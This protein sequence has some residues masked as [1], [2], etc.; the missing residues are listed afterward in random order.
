MSYN[1]YY[2][3]KSYLIVI[4]LITTHFAFTQSEVMVIN[5]YIDYKKSVRSNS[6]KEM[7]SIGFNVAKAV[8]DLRYAG[9]DNFVGKKMYPNSIEGTFMRQPAVIALGR[10]QKELLQQD[11][12]IK[13]FDAYRP[14]SVSKAFWEIVKDERY[15]ANPIR[16]SNH[17]RGTAIDLTIIDIKTG[18]ELNMG[19]GFD[20]FT[21]TAHHSFTHLSG[22]VLKNRSLLKSVMERNGFKA[23]DT[24]WWHYTYQNDMQFEVL[25]IP[26]RRLGKHIR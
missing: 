9:A 1:A 14:Y 18:Q 15:V 23:L 12:G 2:I 17:N 19:T 6:Q 22:D 24:E 8:F 11:L 7:W 10:V 26:F 20:N 25:D 3:K 4:L 21:D 16:G 13:V 5:K